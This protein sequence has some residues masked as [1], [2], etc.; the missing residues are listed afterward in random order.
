MDSRHISQLVLKLY[1]RKIAHSAYIGILGREPDENGLASYTK[2]IASTGNLSTI[3]GDFS[4]SREAWERNFYLHPDELVR[5]I[6]QGLLARAPEAEA[7]YTYTEELAQTKDLSG[8]LSALTHSQE[9]WEKLMSQRSE[10]LVQASFQ[11]LLGRAPDVEALHTYAEQLAQTK[12]LSQMLSALAQSQEHWERLMSQRSEELV[13]ASFQGLLARTPE[14]KALHTYSEQLAQT[15]DLRGLLS[16]LT[17]SQEHWDMLFARKSDEIAGAIFKGILGRAPDATE[18]DTYGSILKNKGKL[19]QFTA[20]INKSEL[21]RR[22]FFSNAA[23]DLVRGIFIGIT[24]REPDANEL[25]NNIPKISSATE[26]QHV[27][28]DVLKKMIVIS[29]NAARNEEAKLSYDIASAVTPLSDWKISD[30]SIILTDGFYSKESGFVWS[31]AKSSLIAN[32]NFSVYLSCNYLSPGEKRYISIDDGDQ[33]FTVTLDDA[34]SCHE[35]KIR[36]Q[37]SKFIRFSSDGSISPQSLGLSSDNRELAFQLWFDIPLSHYISNIPVSV[38]S[39]QTLLCIFDAKK[40]ADSLRPIFERLIELGYTAEFMDTNTAIDYV[41]KNN[42]LLGNFLISSATPYAKLF[43]AGC[44]GR[45]IYAEHGVSPLKKYTYSPHYRRYDLVLLPGVLW[46][47]RL[48]SIYPEMIDRCRVV[49]YPKLQSPVSLSASKRIEMCR[50][51]NLDPEKKLILFAPSWSG[52]DRDC[53]LFNLRFFDNADNLFAIPHDGDVK[54]AKEFSD[55]GYRV[56][57][58]GGNE[59]ISDYYHLADILVSDI[60]STAIEFAAL[61]KPVVCITMK[62][63]PDFDAKFFENESRLRIPHT[64]VYWDFCTLVPREEINIAVKAQ[65][66]L[67]M[68]SRAFADK[69]HTVRMMVD[70]LGEEAA[71]RCVNSIVEMLQSANNLYPIHAKVPL[72][73]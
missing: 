19:E 60:S 50:N 37:L 51:L 32:G 38:G 44:R 6:F 69:S 59:S 57:V 64:D 47:K 34:Y 62:R 54:Y 48:I 66:E 71:D 43:N 9:H 36:S 15:K 63:V 16:A 29:I 72:C 41:K 67:L 11:G 12:D 61:G 14:A 22:D 33:S 40:E 65:Q 39:A 25:A 70:C 73:R 53:G 42:I 31:A 56:R 10:E 20:C 24:G 8:I 45:Y 1:A 7:L 35:I 49:G 18:L 58:L 23:P 46:T 17:Q 26:F 4:R 52:G 55:L 27:I 21:A 13:E 3:L 5:L 2:E 30:T 28:A 68:D